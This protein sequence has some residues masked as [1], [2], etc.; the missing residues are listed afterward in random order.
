MQEE[1]IRDRIVMGISD[2][3]LRHSRLQE[4]KLTL[5]T[6]IECGRASEMM[7][8]QLK[9]M[10]PNEEVS[11]VKKK[12]KAPTYRT[13]QISS[14]PKN[15]KYC[16]RSHPKDK[17]KCPDY[18]KT[19]TYC[20]KKNHFE[21]MCMA[22][23]NQVKGSPRMKK[24]NLCDESEDSDSQYEYIETVNLDTVNAATVNSYDDTKLFTNM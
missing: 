12:G 15:C 1:M 3:R 9:T 24:V 5:K 8:K 13:G 7:S 23:K 4:P 6:P 10:A 2:A 11:A 16:S 22:K 19:C 17:S 18:G 14:W 21:S 20:S